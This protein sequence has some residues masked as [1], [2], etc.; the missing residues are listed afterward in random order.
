MAISFRVIPMNK[1]RVLLKEERL[2]ED[3]EAGAGLGT[4]VVGRQGE[5]SC[6]GRLYQVHSGVALNLVDRALEIIVILPRRSSRLTASW[7]IPPRSHLTPDQPPNGALKD[8][9]RAP[10]YG[11]ASSAVYTAGLAPSSL[12]NICRASQHGINR[13]SCHLC[14]SHCSHHDTKYLSP[15]VALAPDSGRNCHRILV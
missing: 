11:Q 14:D 4:R 7:L 3:I 13:V 15:C 1:H 8:T 5:V 6:G 9:R 12:L 10:G 2:R